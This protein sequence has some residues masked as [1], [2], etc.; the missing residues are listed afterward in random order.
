[1]QK[2]PPYYQYHQLPLCLD[3]LLGY[4]TVIVRKPRAYCI[5]TVNHT[6]VSF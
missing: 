4:R 1:M 3:D 5:D 6:G 2:E